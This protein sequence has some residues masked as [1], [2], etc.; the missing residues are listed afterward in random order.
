MVGTRNV[1]TFADG[2]LDSSLKLAVNRASARFARPIVKRKRKKK[3]ERKKG[4]TIGSNFQERRN[5]IATRVD[6]CR[7]VGHIDSGN[8]L[9]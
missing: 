3:Q 7:E 8:A 5:K 2:S 6:L 1:T 9:K 4:F